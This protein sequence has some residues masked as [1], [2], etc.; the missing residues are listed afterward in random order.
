MH[1]NKLY[2]LG[3]EDKGKKTNVFIEY[4]GIKN[5]FTRLPDSKYTHTNHSLFAY[6]KF[7]ILY[8]WTRN[9]L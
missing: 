7:N 1:N 3:G 8:K 9:G 4:E 5:N 6:E 2:I